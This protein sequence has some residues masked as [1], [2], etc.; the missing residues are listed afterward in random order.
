MIIFNEFTIYRPELIGKRKTK[1]YLGI[2]TSYQL[3]TSTFNIINRQINTKFFTLL[4]ISTTI[5][6]VEMLS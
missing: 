2:K 3:E 1:I 5:V 4:D 6:E